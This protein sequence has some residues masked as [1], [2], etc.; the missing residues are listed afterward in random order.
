MDLQGMPVKE[1]T[2]GESIIVSI[3]VPVPVP[4]PMEPAITVIDNDLLLFASHPS[5]I[6]KALAS[7]QAGG[8][9]LQSATF[10]SDFNQMPEKINGAFYSSKLFSQ[11]AIDLQKNIFGIVGEEALQGAEGKMV[12][13]MISKLA[14]KK[15][16]YLATHSVVDDRGIFTHCNMYTSG[17]NPIAE[18]ITGQLSALPAAFA[19]MTE[20]QSKEIHSEA[21]AGCGT[22]ST[23]LRMLLAENNGSFPTAINGPATNLEGL[24]VYDLGFSYFDAAD[25]VISDTKAGENDYTITCTGT[26]SSGSGQNQGKAA[27]IVLTLDQNGDESITGLQH[28]RPA[29]FPSM[30]A[31]RSKAMSSEAFAGCGTVA[32]VLRIQQLEDGG[33]FR[34]SYNGSALDLLGISET[35]LNGTYFDTADYVV[36]GSKKGSGT[37][38]ITCTGTS[39]SGRGPNKGK[40]EGIIVTLDQ[41]GNDSFTINK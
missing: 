19:L 30:T 16:N 27:G 11:T 18:F 22:T 17:M 2:M 35:D 40:T 3:P 26:P 12:L 36:S 38:I 21:R 33:V 39:T 8:G 37:F 10:K 5:V 13:G 6:K 28:A 25:Y 31:N 7:K 14:A 41:D 34:K 23:V 32:T 29:A 4:I 9:M 20:N 24:D 1:T 15:D